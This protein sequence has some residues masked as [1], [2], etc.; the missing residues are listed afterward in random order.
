MATDS[1]RTIGL[2]GATLVGVGAIVGGGI[3]V[4]AG[5]AFVETGPG[6]L[7]A[8]ALNG[9]VALITA[10][11]FAEISSSFPESGGAYTFAKKVLNVRAAFA[12]GWVLWFAY[13]VAGVLYAV[14]FASYAALAITELW[15]LTGHEAP[16]WLGGRRLMLLLSSLATLV[17]A[18][19]MLR[20]TGEGGRVATIGKL[21]VF[22]VL[23]LAGVVA[24]VGQPL[25]E[26]GAALTPFFPGGAAGLL[27]G[28]GF[29]FIALQGFDLIAA[30]AGKVRAPSRNIPRAMFLSLGAALVVYLPLLLLVATVGVLPGEHI[31][32]LARD[33]PET[34]VAVAAGRF[35]GPIG[36]WLVIVAAV[37]STL[38]ALQANMLAAA[39]VALS[40][41][42]DQTLPAVIATRH[43]RRGTP[44]MAIYATTLTLVAITFMVP[45]LAGAG[46]AASLIFLLSFAL[47]HLTAYLSRSRAV[48][49][50]TDKKRF[51]TPLFPLV[52][53]VGGLACAA[54]AIFQAVVAP[55]AAAIFAIWL[56]LGVMLYL[57]LFA[58]RAESAD[59]W[60]Q[61]LDPNLV[62]LRGQRP[63]VLV[64]VANPDHARALV[65]V[66]NALVPSRI[67][68]VLLLSVVPTPA[69]LSPRRRPTRPLD[70]GDDDDVADRAD[71]ASVSRD[72]NADAKPNTDDEPRA[73]ADADDEP[74]ADADVDDELDAEDEI[75][76]GA[77]VA[78][79]RTSAPASAA[80]PPTAME[81]LASAQEVVTRAL[82]A[83]YASGQTPEALITSAAA[84]WPEIRRIAAEHGCECLL[85]GLR[86][87]TQ[88]PAMAPI[89]ALIND[90]D[91]DVAIL[92]APPGWRLEDAS[93]ILVSVGGRGEQHE[94]RAR[95]LGSLAR[96]APRQ[97]TFFRVV[98]TRAG[99]AEIA[100]AER[101]AE[102][103]ARADLPGHT[104]V[105]ITASDNVA[106]A[107]AAAA[108]DADLLVLGLQVERGGFGMGRSRATFGAITLEIARRAPCATILLSGRRSSIIGF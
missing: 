51:R 46:A 76:A 65:A 31:S 9:V 96:T 106:E 87:L 89:E 79:A 7:V 92:C 103:L 28:M 10:L 58:S 107:V 29:T 1:E 85:L 42:R 39:H 66:A 63:R 20:K 91:C 26:T 83:S 36:Y 69:A 4:L 64:P 43:Q 108:A 40:M 12:V 102:R 105:A 25:R 101:A 22:A 73:D 50:A 48:D 2:S 21:V 60:A 38:S 55:V 93:R 99:A 71:D 33:Q 56:A 35:M 16:A 77:D 62:T 104:D 52:P 84:P 19:L 53:L 72:T 41:A 14:G 74:R 78:V 61:A 6:A 98:P 27:S 97:I 18:G 70:S 23:I 94:L 24:L 49:G 13:I 88:G 8:F 100:E 95:L 59:A 47:T 81:L 30:I 44:V 34:V 5:V 11:S 75:D 86:A 17:Y 67:G 57:A 80:A 3:L 90:V 37:L 45:N 54:L 32:E 15:Q 68:R 82:T